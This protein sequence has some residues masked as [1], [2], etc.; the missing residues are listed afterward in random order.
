[1]LT[2]MVT[3]VLSFYFGIQQRARI[4][5][6]FE[7]RGMSLA[8]TTA[9]NCEHEA[10][11][12][13]GL[14][15]QDLIQGIGSEEDV[16]YVLIQNENGDVLARTHNGIEQE[17][18][19]NEVEEQALAVTESGTF[20]WEASN[21]ARIYDISVVTKG[22]GVTRIGMSLKSAEDLIRGSIFITALL[23]IGLVALSIP[24]TWKIMR[25]IL[26]PLQEL[27]V[28]V[29]ATGEG[30]LNVNISVHDANDEIGQ[31]SSAFSQMQNNLRDM[32]RQIRSISEMVATSVTELSTSS[33][34][35]AAGANE[36]STALTETSSTIEE[37]ATV[38][39]QIAE[40]AKKVAEL[41]DMS[42]N[43]MET[44]RNSTNEG[45]NRIITLGEKSQSIGEVVGMIDDITR[46]TN[47]LALNAS[48][49]AARAG[50]AGKGFAVVATEIRK[51]AT[52]V[53]SSTELIREIIKEIQDATNS[54]VLA[55]EDVSKS[56]DNGIEISKTAADSAVQIHMATQQQKSASD[57][58]V[59]T[60]KEMVTIAQQTAA[61]SNQIAETADRLSQATKEQKN[62][63]EQ[64]K[65][66]N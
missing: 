32:V 14:R 13:Q 52:N 3:V 40:N 17:A 2:V 51:L 37:L 20:T 65:I 63:V 21:R 24:I 64:F 16:A 61:G 44:I 45:A 7:T 62:L 6:E 18:L 38:S 1:M 35:Q 12:N 39:S 31:L 15:L 53:A 9:S 23:T 54:S 30:D 28:C 33:N 49:E 5:K 43:G 55:T 19:G 11:R 46:Q 22:V 59:A 57:Q 42:F 50:D 27:L 8:K 34:E 60:I 66:G 48:I 41:A 58:M 47:L 29:Q 25:I 26:N 4:Y 56:V 10:R 36:Q